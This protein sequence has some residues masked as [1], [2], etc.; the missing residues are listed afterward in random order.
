MYISMLNKRLIILVAKAYG[1]IHE[2]QGRFRTGY[3]MNDNAFTL[4]SLV[5]K[6]LCEKGRKLY[7]AYF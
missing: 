5:G 7:V 3:S 4:Q 6:Y 2:T 1:K